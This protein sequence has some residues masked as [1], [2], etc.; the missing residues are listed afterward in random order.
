AAAPPPKP[1]GKGLVSA[2]PP[3]AAKAD[4]YRFPGGLVPTKLP[5]RLMQGRVRTSRSG[6]API[7]PPTDDD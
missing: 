3:P 2:P 4:S 1:G 7:A 5:P 6:A